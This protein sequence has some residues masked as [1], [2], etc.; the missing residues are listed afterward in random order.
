ML[1]LALLAAIVPQFNQVTTT[2]TFFGCNRIEGDDYKATLT[3][4]PSS[5]NLP[6]LRLNLQDIATLNPNYAFFGG[7]NIL[8]Y[9]DDQ[10]ETLTSQTIAW[11]NLLKFGPRGS[12]TQFVAIPGNHELLRKH[13]GNK[14]PAPL[15]DPIW[16]KLVTDAGFIPPNA[17][18]PTE[19]EAKADKFTTNQDKL[20]FS[21]DN[22]NTHFVVLNTDT[23]VDNIDPKTNLN[24]IA[25]LA[26][27]WIK[28]DLARAEANPKITAIIVMG[29]RNLCEPA[30]SHGDS[31]IDAESGN[32]L[33]AS[34]AKS[35]KV[36]AYLCAHVHSYDLT[37]IPGTHVP[38]IVLGNGGSKLEDDWK[39]AEGRTFGF[40]YFKVFSDGQLSFTPYFRPAPEPYN[41]EK[42]EDLPNA[43]PHGELL[44]PTHQK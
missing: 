7:D 2:F 36:R 25:K 17:V 15:A 1:P 9:A 14:V 8:G 21:F 3:Q 6:Q 24:K 33:I 12:N 22:E 13:N 38:Q 42:P 29:H 16:S 41:S 5:A 39:P 23:H 4:N 27:T 43:K 18:P 32:S 31:P 26:V 37:E 20:N 35:P 19:E 40:G 44:F 28:N 30:N 10:G 34:I 11:I